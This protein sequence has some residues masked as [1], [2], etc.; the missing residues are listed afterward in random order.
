MKLSTLLSIS[1]AVAIASAQQPA[2]AQCGGVNWSGGSICVSGFYCFKQN[3]FYSQCIPGT[4]TTTAA[5]TTA[6]SGSPAT[7]TIAPPV[8]SITSFA[9]AAGNVFNINGKSQYFMGTNSYWI[10]FFT[11]NDDVDLVFSHLASTGLKVLRVWGFND[12]T[13]I[14]SAGNVWFQSFVKGSTPTINTGADG[15]QRL[16]YVVESAG[17]HGVSLIINFVNNWSDY[18]GM[19]AYRSYYNLSTTDQSQWYTSAAVQAQYQKYIAT[20]VARYK[21]NPTVFSWELA[22]EPRC[23]GCATSVVTNWI[24]TTS[25]YIKSLDSK[26]M[27]CIGDEGFGI[28]GGTDTSYPFGPGEGI[29]WV[30]NLKISTI[31]FG[32]AH[33]YPESWGETD[34]WGTSWINIHAAAAK[35]IGKPVILEEYGTATKANILVWQKAVMDSGTAADMYWQYGD[36]FSWGQTHNDGHSIYYGTAEYKTYVEDH[37]AAMAAKA[38]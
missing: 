37:A 27:V 34:A 14:P 6:T 31:D 5:T 23:N 19:A 28:D 17:K 18:G 4:A 1:S 7:S 12:V 13:T 24:K 26:H 36:T 2:Y 21:D 22:N 8:A 33:L 15:L 9:K 30:A 20:V 11:S 25:A 16:D 29:D 32:T 10:G 35:T 38:V 3:E